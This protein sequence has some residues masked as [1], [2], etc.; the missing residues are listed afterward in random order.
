M[1]EGQSVGYLGLPEEERMKIADPEHRYAV[2]RQEGVA[3]ECIYPTIGLYAW[4]LPD[5]DAGAASCRIYNE[6]IA[7]TLGRSPRFRCAGIVP[8]W[9][10]EDAVREVEWLAENGFASIMLPAVAAPEWNHT[11]W[12][13]LWAAAEAS[14]MPIVIHQGTGHDMYFY[15][16]LGA[17]VSKPVGDSVDGAPRGGSVR[18]VWRPGQPSRPARGVRRVQRRVAGLD[19]ADTRFLHGLI[20]QVRQDR[21]RQE[22]DQPRTARATELLLAPTDPRD[23]PR[24]SGRHP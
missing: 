22:L 2:M 24:R 23:V 15:R 14:G 18:H 12:E 1:L 6:W 9:R 20:P 3:G 21:D 16:G 7:S 17:G 10:V 4:M 13:P 11:Q 5:A 8:T 19:H